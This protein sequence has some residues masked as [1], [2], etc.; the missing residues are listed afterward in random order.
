MVHRAHSSHI[1]SCLSI[2]DLLAVLY[3]GVLYIDAAH[4]DAPD[5]DR[6]ILSK[7]HAAAIYYAVLAERGFFPKSWL[8]S[9]GEDG[10]PL[11]GH[12]TKHGVP[13]VEFSTGSLGHGLSI[14]CGIALSAKRSGREFRTY[15]L[16]GD[17]ECGEGSIWEAALFAAHHRLNNL[18]VLVD[19]NKLQG[20]DRVQEVLTLGDLGG[21]WAAFGWAVEYVDGHDH[22]ALRAALLSAKSQPKK[23]T[24]LIAHTIKGSGV[25]YMEDQLIWHYKSPDEQQLEQALQEVAG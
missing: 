16:L 1:G 22:E 7:G 12:V 25:S 15:V 18:V 24:A 8:D 3:G 23:P 20:L 17:G 4:P 21:K 9:Y 2:A 6:F 11:A 13:G 5:R 10:S 19:H 14:G